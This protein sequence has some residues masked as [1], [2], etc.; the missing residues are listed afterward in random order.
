MGQFVVFLFGNGSSWEI[1][2]SNVDSSEIFSRLQEIAEITD[3]E[4]F[5]VGT[6]LNHCFETVFDF[7][8]LVLGLLLYSS[9]LLE[10]FLIDLV[11]AFLLLLLLDLVFDLVMSLLG[12]A[13]V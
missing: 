12:L 6:G 8:F 3:E 10:S 13:V 4:F 9:L 2:C 11:E 7:L 1:K 5:V